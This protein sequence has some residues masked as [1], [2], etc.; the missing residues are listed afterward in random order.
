MIDAGQG[1]HNVELTTKPNG[2]MPIVVGGKIRRRATRAIG[3]G[4]AMNGCI[5][6][7]VVLEI[8]M[9]VGGMKAIAAEIGEW[10]YKLGRG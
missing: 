1:R 10:L 8:T 6:S 4:T 3:S 5:D 9:G 2:H 7:I